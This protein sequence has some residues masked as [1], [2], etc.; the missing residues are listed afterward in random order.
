[1][2]GHGLGGE[3]SSIRVLVVDD[4]DLFRRG[5][6]SAFG[7]EPDIEVVAQASGGLAGVRL[8]SEL[9]PDVV[10]LDLQ[11]PDLD[12]VRATEEI[13]ARL[14]STRI[15]ILTVAVEESDVGAALAAGAQGYVV[16]DSPVEDVVAAVRAAARGVAWL[17]PG[18]AARLTS[19]VRREHPV[20]GPDVDLSPREREVLA[21]IAVG[22]DNSEIAAK[23]QISPATAKKHVSNV[24]TKLAVPNRIQA[25]VYAVRHGLD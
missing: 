16:K 19:Y 18:A 7:G 17:S 22:M 9:Q 10:L 14:P 2:T 15:V 12:G 25:A 1:M 24:L 6:C 3:H 4:H 13:L 23:L 8:A 21:L 20:T 11:M 5:L